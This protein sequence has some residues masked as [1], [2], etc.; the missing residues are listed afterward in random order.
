MGFG[1]LST[2]LPTWN[3]IAR[4]LAWTI[5]TWQWHDETRAKTVDLSISLFDLVSH[6]LVWIPWAEAEGLVS[7][8]CGLGIT[9]L[10]GLTAKVAAA[11]RPG[12][13]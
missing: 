10:A 13:M 2:T 1:I 6:S 5:E 4:W 12:C 7:P 8:T 9:G 11:S 3:D